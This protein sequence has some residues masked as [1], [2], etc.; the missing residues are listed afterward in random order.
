MGSKIEISTVAS[1]AKILKIGQTFFS[2]FDQTTSGVGGRGPQGH[3]PTHSTGELALVLAQWPFFRTLILGSKMDISTV[4][5]IA[6]ILKIGQTFFSDFDQ[7]TSGVGGLG[8]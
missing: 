3:V 6:K 1:V 2:D 7:T 5:S 8:P 4:A